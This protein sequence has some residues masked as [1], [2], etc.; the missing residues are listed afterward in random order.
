MSSQNVLQ[1]ASDVNAEPLCELTGILITP[2]TTD[3]ILE[4]NIRI[5][6]EHVRTSGAVVFKGFNLDA[7]LFEQFSNSLSNDFMNNMGS[8]SWRKTQNYSSDGTIQNVTYTYGIG[9]QRTF[10]LP[11]HADRAYVKSRPEVMF[12]MCERPAAEGGRTTVCDGIDAYKGFSKSTR[13]LLDR[14]RLKYIRHYQDGEW[15]TLYQTHDF[16]LIEKYCADYDM[17]LDRLRD[18]SIRTEYVHTGVPLTKWQQTK[19]FCNSMQIGLWQEYVMGRK[20][21]FVRFEDDSEIP[22]DVRQ[23][24]DEVTEKLTAEI[25][26]EAG[27][28]AIVDNTRMLHGRRS[29]TDENRSILVRMCRSVE[30]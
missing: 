16:S 19:S 17:L 10:P 13:E 9:H 20:T 28:I 7:A 22:E 6:K 26:W 5:I 25:P 14:K 23:E 15:Q 12:F 8:G 27:D 24:I 4:L 21:T 3:N 1:Q 2:S 29:F 30:W 18:N 11:L